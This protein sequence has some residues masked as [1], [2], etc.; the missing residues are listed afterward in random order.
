MA[1]REI[2]LDSANSSFI[3]KVELDGRPFSFR[4]K[5]NDRT[6][7]WSIDISDDAGVLLVA[8]IPLFVKQL[9]I[10]RYQHK[11][12]LPQGSLF[13]INQVDEDLPPTRDNLGVDVLLLYDEVV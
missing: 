13:A 9:L 12:G 7:L 4:F 11:E 1:I 2:P 5:F 3:Q 8:G 10:D 6:E